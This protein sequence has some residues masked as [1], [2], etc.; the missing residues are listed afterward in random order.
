M[1]AT[2]LKLLSVNE[3]NNLFILV[4]PKSIIFYDHS[5]NFLYSPIIV[6]YLGYLA[7]E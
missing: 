1:S 3:V 6:C 4:A 5:S 2:L 7:D